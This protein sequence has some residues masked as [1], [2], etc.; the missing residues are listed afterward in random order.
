MF[1]IY[2]AVVGQ[3]G[4]KYLAFIQNTITNLANSVESREH[5]WKDNIGILFY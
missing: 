4:V 2:S 5:N 1:R 3:S